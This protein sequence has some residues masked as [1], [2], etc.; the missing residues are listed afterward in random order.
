MALCW[1]WWCLAAAAGTE[2]RLLPR[3]ST[4]A[5]HLAAMVA[6]SCILARDLGLVGVGSR[7]RSGRCWFFH[8]KQISRCRLISSKRVLRLQ[9]GHTTLSVSRSGTTTACC[10]VAVA[11]AVVGRG[12]AVVWAPFPGEPLSLAKSCFCLSVNSLLVRIPTR[13][14]WGHKFKFSSSIHFK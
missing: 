12:G 13:H 14:C 3:L 9:T 6:P 4:R 10:V 7:D 11:V 2:C 5:M 8:N 1:L